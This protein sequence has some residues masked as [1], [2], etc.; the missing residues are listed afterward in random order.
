M[1]KKWS[2]RDFLKTS[3]L[4]SAGTLLAACAPAAQPQ[5][6]AGATPAAQATNPPAAG[7]KK[8]VFSA[9]TWSNFEAKMTE[10]L[11]GW[12]AATPNVTYEGQFVPQSID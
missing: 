9:Y 2:R 3:A 10:I 6:P 5:A 11:N 8:V 1:S 4:L 7:K 12:V